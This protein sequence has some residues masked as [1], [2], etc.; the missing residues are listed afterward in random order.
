MRGGSQPNRF[1][2]RL[3]SMAARLTRLLLP[4]ALLTGC[5]TVAETGRTQW[6][7][8]SEPEMQKLAVKAYAEETGKHPIIT[9]GPQWEMVERVG[10]RIAENSGRDYPWEFKLLDAPDTVNAFALPGGKI[11]VYSGL[12]AVA[13]DDDSLAAVLGH[14]VAH[15][16]SHHGAERMSHARF[17]EAGLSVAQILVDEW[18]KP[19]SATKD[20]IMKALGFATTTG[21]M[22]PYSRL[23]E[24]EADEIGLR[25]LIRAGY[26]PYAAPKVWER[27]AELDP[28]RGP[29]FFSTHP[30][31]LNRAKALRELIPRL[32]AEERVKKR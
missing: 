12:L 31:P 7:L 23:H 6:V 9:G 5:Q 17:T 27:M 11:A 20:G 26:D 19:D 4:F 22:L 18:D 15:A 2:A 3:K 30:D 28:S 8:F 1:P 24:S 32:V 29:E 16:T 10:R 14:E 13:P 25:F 21:L